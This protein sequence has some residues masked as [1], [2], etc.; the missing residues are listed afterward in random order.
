VSGSKL[1]AARD[2]EKAVRCAGGVLFYGRGI[3]WV[4]PDTC[5]SDPLRRL[6]R[7][8]IPE[9]TAILLERAL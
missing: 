7:T 5:L 4:Y 3:I 6:I 8:H 9:L 1:V 2:I